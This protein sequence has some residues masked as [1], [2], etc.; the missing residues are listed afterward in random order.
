MDKPKMALSTTSQATQVSSF[1]NRG[2]DP[3]SL[4]FLMASIMLGLR[5]TVIF[6]IIFSVTSC[7]CDCNETALYSPKDTLVTDVTDK[8]DIPLIEPQSSC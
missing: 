1:L 8:Y 3:K 4:G 7:Y 6:L 2:R 5:V